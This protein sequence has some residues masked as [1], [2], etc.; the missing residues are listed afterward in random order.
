ML[1]CSG[2][3]KRSTLPLGLL[4]LEIISVNILLHFVNC[5]FFRPLTAKGS[6]N[7]DKSHGHL[8]QDWFR[9]GTTQLLSTCIVAAHARPLLLSKH[10]LNPCRHRLILVAAVCKT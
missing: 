2:L 9:A 7:S 8:G 10:S 1:I 5:A 4:N 6:A 3:S